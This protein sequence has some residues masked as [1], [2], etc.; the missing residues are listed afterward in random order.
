M[1][2]H[3]AP[4]P[5]NQG[6]W[7][8][9]QCVTEFPVGPIGYDLIPMADAA[10]SV[11][12]AADT[13]TDCQAACH[14]N[15]ACQYYVFWDYLAS[16]QRCFLRDKVPYSDIDLNDTSKSYVLFQVGFCKTNSCSCHMASA[17]RMHV[18]NFL[19]EALPLL[20]PLSVRP[21][22]PQCPVPLPLVARAG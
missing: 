22:C 21:S 11:Q 9:E 13:A 20:L 4:S 14:A 18:C 8:P 5:H 16:G 2:P 3:A 7:T 17:Q 15:A 6:S 1:R 19:R 10:L 12:P